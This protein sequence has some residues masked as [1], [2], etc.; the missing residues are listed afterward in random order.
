LISQ[1]NPNFEEWRHPQSPNWEIKDP[2]FGVAKRHEVLWRITHN[3]PPNPEPNWE[4]KDQAF[5]V[6]KRHGVLWRITHD[7]SP[8]T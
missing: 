8:R 5:G 7:W 6:A 2:A 1:T 4:T 3:W